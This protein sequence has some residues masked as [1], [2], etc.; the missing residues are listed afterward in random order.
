MT[1]GASWLLLPAA[2]H[3][4]VYIDPR[5]PL[6]RVRLRSDGIDAAVG[7]S[8]PIVELSVGRLQAQLGLTGAV[9]MGFEPGES[10]TF[11]L[12]TFDGLF[13]A[14]LD[15]RWRDWEARLQWT[16]LSAHFGDG[17]RQLD[18]PPPLELQGAFSREWVAL[19]LGR[20]LLP[21]TAGLQELYAFAGGRAIYHAVDDGGGP[22]LWVGAQADWLER[23]GPYLA[24]QLMVA[25]EQQWTPSVSVQAGGR[26][27]AGGGVRLGGV[28]YTGRGQAGKA[29]GEPE[30]HV[31][32]QIA[33]GPLPRVR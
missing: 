5:E 29:T 32:L 7:D 23:H 16:H 6:S 4:P 8:V 14:P 30:Q 31:G 3:S 25:A 12:L 2:L 17:V 33:F 28:F 20:H 1:V 24:A 19:T 27:G 10:L 15:L 22:A 26:L 11:Y 13:G 18:Q 21:G 9:F